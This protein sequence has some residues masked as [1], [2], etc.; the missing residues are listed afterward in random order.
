MAAEHPALAGGGRAWALNE[1]GTRALPQQE[2]EEEQ[3]DDEMEEDEIASPDTLLGRILHPT[4]PGPP[5]PFA[6]VEVGQRIGLNACAYVR[7]C[8]K[9][10]STVHLGFTL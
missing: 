4:A 6:G 9:T 2:D 10:T 7:A 8:T 5:A 1:D 3:Q